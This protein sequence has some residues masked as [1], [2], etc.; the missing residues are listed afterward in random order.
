SN[1]FLLLSTA[2]LEWRRMFQLVCTSKVASSRVQ[3]PLRTYN[4]QPLLVF[5]SFL[6]K[7]ATYFSYSWTHHPAALALSSQ[8][9]RNTSDYRSKDL[10]PL[11][12]VTIEDPP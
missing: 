12:Q 7:K 1:G 3:S 10:K 8:H 6:G 4:T 5:F 2:Y 11:D 9:K